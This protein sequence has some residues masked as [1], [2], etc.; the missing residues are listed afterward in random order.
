MM[1]RTVVIAA[2]PKDIRRSLPSTCGGVVVNIRN[3][4]SSTLA[5]TIT[6]GYRGTYIVSTGVEPASRSMHLVRKDGGD[7]DVASDAGPC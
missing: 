6:P 3:S 7:E 5:S 1:T 2:V 4:Y